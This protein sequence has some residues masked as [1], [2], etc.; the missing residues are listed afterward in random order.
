[1]NTI[2]S[3]TPSTGSSL[4]VE[5][6][7]EPVD[8][9][10]DQ[11]FGRR[12]AGGDAEACARPRASRSRSRSPRADQPGA[13]ALALGDLDQPHRVGAVGRADHQHRVAARGDRLDRG[14]AVRGGV[15][16]VLAA[17]RLDASGSGARRIATISRGVVDRQGRLGQEGEIVGIG[18]RDRL[19][20]L[21]RSRPGVIRPS[22]T[23]P[24]VP[25]TSGW[26]A[27]PT[28][29]MWRP[30]LDQP[31]GLAMDLGDERAGGVEIVEAALLGLGRHRLGHAVGRE[32]HR[33]A[34][35][36]LV[37]LG[38]EDRA[39]A[40]SG[41]RRRTCCGR[42]RGGHRPARRSA[43]SP[44]RRCGSRGRPRRRSRAARRSAG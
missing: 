13:D 10:A 20:V 42:S 43:R 5:M 33:H 15:A 44:A 19:G 18:G 17:R 3:S 26:P 39:L 24:K 25:I 30:L 27:W 35:G 21:R 11:H 29:R 40:P 41:C 23:W 8:H 34:V 28:N 6:L 22:G 2:R 37:Q 32:D 38:D 12:G 36:H 9:F 16:N 7:G 31:L 1:M 14:L 4:I